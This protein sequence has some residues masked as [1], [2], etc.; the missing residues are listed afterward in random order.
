MTFG[1]VLGTL[2][3]TVMKYFWVLGAHVHAVLMGVRR[4]TEVPMVV[5]VVAGNNANALSC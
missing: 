5:S 4:G 1:V 3:P 2:H